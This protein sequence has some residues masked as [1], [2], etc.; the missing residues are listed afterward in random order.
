MSQKQKREET[1]CEMGG[2]TFQPG[3][4]PVVLNVFAHDTG[5]EV[6]VFFNVPDPEVGVFTGEYAGELAA[7]T[8]PTN[9][10]PLAAGSGSRYPDTSSFPN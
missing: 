8:I 7:L 10:L 1:K 3:A 9:E 4:G 2:L 5:L 6:G